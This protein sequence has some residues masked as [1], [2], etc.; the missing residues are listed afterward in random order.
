MDTSNIPS[1]L[2]TKW[3]ALRQQYHRNALPH[4]IL[5]TG[6]PGIGKSQLA[7]QFFQWLH[8]S[9]HQENDEPCGHC[10]SC[11]LMTTNTHPDHHV[12]NTE[13][14]IKIDHIRRLSNQQALTPHSGLWRTSLITA[15][16]KMTTSA[17]N[18]LL[19]LL[20]EPPPYRLF[21]L[22]AAAMEH[23]PVT[24]K[25]RC[26][27]HAIVTPPIQIG[28]QWL[29]RHTQRD[30][31]TLQTALM[32]AGE[33]PQQALQYIQTGR[34]EAITNLMHSFKNLQGARVNIPLLAEQWQESD[35][36]LITTHIQRYCQQQ[37][38]NTDAADT[39]QYYLSLYNDV[40]T[41]KK[42]LLSRHNMNRLLIIEHFMVT[43]MHK[44]P[45]FSATLGQDNHGNFS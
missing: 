37:L 1:W 20:E 10:R 24:I 38:L 25:S 39:R 14:T 31:Q 5:L 45:L 43:V 8:C 30:E 6:K 16:D 4:A 7:T 3:Q 41:M 22:T 2:Q 11:Q 21:I 13:T 9:Q 18:A 32:L 34:V 36:E 19:K 35:I 40:L 23:I 28:L 17:Y 44:A 15:A 29:H 33:V 12:I 42:Q 27:H 26:Q